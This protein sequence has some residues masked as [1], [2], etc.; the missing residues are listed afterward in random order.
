MRLYPQNGYSLLHHYHFLGSFVSKNNFEYKMFVLQTF[1]CL[2]F[3]PSENLQRVLEHFTKKPGN[4]HDS[5]YKLPR[6]TQ[7]IAPS[8]SKKCAPS[9]GGDCPEQLG[10]LPRAIS[11]YERKLILP[12]SFLSSHTEVT[13]GRGGAPPRW[14]IRSTFAVRR[15]SPECMA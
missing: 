13:A 9:N 14:A 5:C 6:A 15:L 4:C 1:F 11:C 10:E 7:S 8:N 2:Y 12:Q 3:L